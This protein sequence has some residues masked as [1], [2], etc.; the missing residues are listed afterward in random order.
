MNIEILPIK[1]YYTKKMPGITH[2][3]LTIMDVTKPMNGIQGI[4]HME[5][6]TDNMIKD[7]VKYQKNLVVFESENFDNIHD[8]TQQ[9]K[10]EFKRR[11]N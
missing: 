4:V 5:L 6:L 7:E 1:F 11:F 9:F 10:D 3:F 2:S 8:Y